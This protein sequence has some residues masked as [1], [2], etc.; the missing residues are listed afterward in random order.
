MGATLVEV[1]GL[2]TV[3]AYLVAEQGAVGPAG[4]SSC[5]SW[6]LEHRLDSCGTQA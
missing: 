3:V 6:A 4:F 5:G 2:L 1:H